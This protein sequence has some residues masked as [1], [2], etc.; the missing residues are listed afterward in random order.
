M[1]LSRP[2]HNHSIIRT[3]KIEEIREAIAQIYAKPTLDPAGTTRV[4]DAAIY[5]CKLQHISIGYGR[6][7]APVSVEFPAVD[8]FTQLIPVRGAGEIA[9]GKASIAISGNGGATISP[10][11]G[12]K[13]IYDDSYEH[14]VIQ[15]DAQALTTKLAALA[16]HPINEPLRIDPRVD[17]KRPGASALSTYIPL[18]ANTLTDAKP[19]FPR[20][21]VSQ[22]EQLV[23][24][25]F[26]YGHRHNYSH[27]LERNPVDTAPWQIRRTEEYIENNWQEPISLEDLMQVSGVGA[28][29]LF[30]T[31]RKIRGYS[32]FEF[33]AQVRAKRKG[34]YQ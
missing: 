5:H 3:S 10:D 28:L 17:L 20:W 13:G 27:L 18:L 26:L 34:G 11:M 7:G 15:I 8:R 23:M 16:G 31:F 22:T 32:P 6:Y 21:W 24:V 33:L 2:L 29:D 25:M 12:Y 14:I 1:K 19:P 30:R 4:L 9:H